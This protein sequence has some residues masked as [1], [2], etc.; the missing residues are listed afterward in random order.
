MKDTE[1]LT[2]SDWGTV[3]NSEDYFLFKYIFLF[4]LFLHECIL[5]FDA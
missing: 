1:T 2:F 4:Y 3:K 5:T